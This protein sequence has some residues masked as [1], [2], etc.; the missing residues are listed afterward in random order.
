MPGDAVARL[1]HFAAEADAVGA[2]APLELPRIAVGQPGFR[3]LDLPAIVDALAEHAVHI[4]DAIAVSRDAEA[5]EALHEAGRQPP[6]AAIAER[7]VGFQ[8]LQ[9]RQIEA[10]AAQRLFHLAGQ[11]HVAQRIAQQPADEEFEAEIIDPLAAI[12]IGFAG[13]FHPAVDDLVAQRQDGGGEPVMRLGGALVLAD[14]VA[15]DIDDQRV[16][17]RAR[18]GLDSWLRGDW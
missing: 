1:D 11:P 9:L 14:A 15:Q 10:M 7:R 4:A 8:I 3:Q 5:G 13:R 17:L 16:D 12:R 2:L 18:H 6:E